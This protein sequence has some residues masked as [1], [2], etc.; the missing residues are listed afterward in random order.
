MYVKKIIQIYLKIIINKTHSNNRLV[1]TIKVIIDENIE[2]VLIYTYTTH[3][4]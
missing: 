1:Y 2:F 4:V 3:N